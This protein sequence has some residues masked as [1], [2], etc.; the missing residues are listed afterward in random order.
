M[1]TIFKTIT[2]FRVHTH[3]LEKL[4]R[5]CYGFSAGLHTIFP[6]NTEQEEKLFLLLQRAYLDA[7]YT[8]T[9][10]ISTEELRLIAA[11]IDRLHQVVEFVTRSWLDLLI[12]KKPTPATVF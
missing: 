3:N 6:R 9:Y 7:R 11:R 12:I 8:D 10:H 1:L 2:W 4:L 5:Y